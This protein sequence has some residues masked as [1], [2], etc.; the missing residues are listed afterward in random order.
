MSD[1]TSNAYIHRLQVTQTYIPKML[2][3]NL[4]EENRLKPM[5]D[6][7][8]L[9]RIDGICNL[10]TAKFMA[11]LPAKKLPD[12]ICKGFSKV[13]SIHFYPTRSAPS[14]QY[15]KPDL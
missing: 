12:S 3:N 15:H 8:E 9:F 1:E 2:R 6:K 14:S 11:K 4:A 10:E 13:F 5:Y 7:L